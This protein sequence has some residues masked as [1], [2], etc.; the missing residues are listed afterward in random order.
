MTLRG[1]GAG[2]EHLRPVDALRLRHLAQPGKASLGHIRRVQSGRI[3]SFGWRLARRHGF[4]GHAA[5]VDLEVWR[6]KGEA[7]ERGSE[8]QP[9]KARSRA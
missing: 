4:L 7:H 5:G 9:E 2:L 3:P 8:Q 6:K 1:G